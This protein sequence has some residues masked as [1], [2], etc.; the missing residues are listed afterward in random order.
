LLKFEYIA[1]K[2]IFVFKKILILLL[3]V[4]LSLWSLSSGNVL[5]KEIQTEL[6]MKKNKLYVVDFFAS[7]CKSCKKELPLIS[8]LY[9]EGTKDIIGI[10]VD[11]D[12]GKAKAFVEKLKIP[13][14]VIYDTDQKLI[15]LF[16][17]QGFP[18]LYYIKNGKI[19]KSI[20]GAVDHID[21][22]IKKD[23]KE[24]K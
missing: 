18:T 21:R 13:F 10:N 6:H 12:G 16:K 15:N 9:S 11:K 1:K 4:P 23:I 3:I 14:P 19:L 8:H 17:P 20:T 7:W 2:E 24:L 5:S 22:E